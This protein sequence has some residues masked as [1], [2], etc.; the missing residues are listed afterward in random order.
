M[1]QRIE[2]KLSVDVFRRRTGVAP[3]SNFELTVLDAPFR[4]WMKSLKS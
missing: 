4:D 1:D 3:V 2:L